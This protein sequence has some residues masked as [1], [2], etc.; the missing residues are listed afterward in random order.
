MSD[1]KDNLIVRYQECVRRI[2]ANFPDDPLPADD[3]AHF[4]IDRFEA[5]LDRKLIYI[6]TGMESAVIEAA[7][8]FRRGG[9]Y[10]H[11]DTNGDEFADAVDALIASRVEDE[12]PTGDM[13]TVQ[14]DLL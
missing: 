1:E 3:P 4:W 14:E 2:W 10:Y 6:R 11:I 12:T 9:F 7:V 8:K 5:L 13:N